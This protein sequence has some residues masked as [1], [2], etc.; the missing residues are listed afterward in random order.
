MGH[1]QRPRLRSK[2]AAFREAFCLEGRAMK[3]MLMLGAAVALLAGVAAAQETPREPAASRNDRPVE[4]KKPSGETTA[5]PNHGVIFS[6]EAVRS[7]GVVTVE[8][9]PI[10]YNAV[11]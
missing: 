5:Q 9:Q 4:T 7:E 11:A 8:G 1:L 3:K 6:P 2:F 10:A